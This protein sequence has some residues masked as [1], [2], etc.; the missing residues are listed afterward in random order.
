MKTDQTT[1]AGRL[2]RTDPEKMKALIEPILQFMGENGI[3]TVECKMDGDG[4]TFRMDARKPEAEAAA[5]MAKTKETPT[6]RT[7]A[8]NRN[9]SHQ[10]QTWMDFAVT[11]ERELAELK[12][13][14]AG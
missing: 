5:P 12:A 14:V 13:V 6:P 2:R 1:L 7:D 3:H 8:F 11:L 4:G 10:S 9:Y